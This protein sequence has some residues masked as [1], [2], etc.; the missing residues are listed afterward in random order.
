MPSEASYSLTYDWVVGA[1]RHALGRCLLGVYPRVSREL[2][3]SGMAKLRVHRRT[4]DEVQVRL[5]QSTGYARLDRESLMF[6]QRCV[7]HPSVKADI[8]VGHALTAPVHWQL[9][10]AE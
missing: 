10:D 1:T 5:I 8:P 4:E 3:E 2:G 9:D 7:E 6:V